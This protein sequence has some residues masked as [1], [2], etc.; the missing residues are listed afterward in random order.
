MHGI[1]SHISR[2]LCIRHARSVPG[3]ECEGCLSQA[4]PTITVRIR[5]VGLAPFCA[6]RDPS[7]P[8]VRWPHD[9]LRAR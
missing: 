8:T 3:G 5:E 1:V 7:Q 4:G 2:G 6:W 9:V